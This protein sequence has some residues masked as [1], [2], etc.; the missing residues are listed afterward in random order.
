MTRKIA[1]G[2]DIPRT[3]V[4]LCASVLVPYLIHLLPAYQNVPMGA[5]LLPMF[6]APLIAVFYMELPVVILVSL[7][8]PLL[9]YIL[10]G[11]PL[12]GNVIAVTVELFLFSTAAVMMSKHKVLRYFIP[13]S[14]LMVKL[15]G[16]IVSIGAL[17]HATIHAWVDAV[18]VALPGVGLLYILVII[19]VSR[20]C[21]NRS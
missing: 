3:F 20:T 17:N 15:F 8:A 9:N 4:L 5:R 21:G 10:T 7:S 18:S 19:L 13:V 2:M 14:Y 1:L 12:V 6:Y 16:A 11:H